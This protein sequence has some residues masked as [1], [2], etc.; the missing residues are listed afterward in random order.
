MFSRD[1]YKSKWTEWS[2]T[3]E[4]TSCCVILKSNSQYQIEGTSCGQ[5]KISFYT[6]EVA[7]GKNLDPGLQ[8]VVIA[9]ANRWYLCQPS[10][11]SVNHLL[12]HCV[13]TR[14]LKELSFS[15]FGA[16]WVQAGSLGDAPLSWRGGFVGKEQRKVWQA[17]HSCLFQSLWKAK[18]RIASW[19]D[20]SLFRNLKL[21]FF[22]LLWSGMNSSIADS[23]SIQFEFIDWVGCKCVR[24]CIFA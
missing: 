2:F 15:L 14:L 18:K 11:E 5:P 22:F 20:I 8:R 19:D 4:E 21:C 6:W 23:P 7:W 17:D 16:T 1:W 3:K 13:R 10:E 9:L 24:F 12:L